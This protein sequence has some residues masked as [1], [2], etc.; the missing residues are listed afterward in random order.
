MEK[1]LNGRNLEYS[2]EE[3]FESRSKKVEVMLRLWLLQE[4]IE[5]TIPNL[6]ND[7]HDLLSGSLKAT[8]DNV[9]K[10]KASEAIHKSQAANF[11]EEANV[12]IK[13]A[14]MALIFVKRFEQ[15]TLEM[16]NILNDQCIRIGEIISN[17]IEELKRKEK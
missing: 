16:Y 13:E 1:T 4:Q 5:H 11:L 10:A 6:E 8:F 12:S 2:N 14:Q 3:N 15:V 17:N 9:F 7:L